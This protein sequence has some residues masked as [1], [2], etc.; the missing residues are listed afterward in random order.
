MMS[1]SQRVCASGLIAEVKNLFIKSHLGKS[2]QSRVPLLF[3]LLWAFL[4]RLVVWSA[5]FIIQKNQECCL[6]DPS[7][8]WVITPKKKVHVSL[9]WQLMCLVPLTALQRRKVNKDFSRM[10][11][12]CKGIFLWQILCQSCLKCRYCRWRELSVGLTWDADLGSAA[13]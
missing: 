11:S 10:Y 7:I 1:L 12:A 13:L 3:W 2:Q 8:I 4:S 9:P 6:Q 5:Y